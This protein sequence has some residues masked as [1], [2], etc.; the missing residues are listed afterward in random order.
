MSIAACWCDLPRAGAVGNRDAASY[1]RLGTMSV[2]VSLLLVA[3]QT[4]SG[5]NVAVGLGH[6]AAAIDI[7][8]RWRESLHRLESDAARAAYA[9]KDDRVLRHIAHAGASGRTVREMM[10]DCGIATLQEVNNILDLLR[11]ADPVVKERDTAQKSLRQMQERIKRV[12]T[13]YTLG[14]LSEP[15]FL[16]QREQLRGQIAEIE[17]SR[18]LPDETDKVIDLGM[19][20]ET[21]SSLWAEASPE[22]KRSIV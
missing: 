16:R 3:I 12:Q 21:V 19:M 13:L 22:E 6:A 14:D 2:K 18:A 17:R 4:A 11:Q 1:A 10:R 5:S 20:L 15:D 8:E 7:C 9:G